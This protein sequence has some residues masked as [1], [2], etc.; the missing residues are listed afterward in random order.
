MECC[1]KINNGQIDKNTMEDIVMK[2]SRKIIA[3]IIL[4]VFVLTNS[5]YANISAAE[6]QYGIGGPHIEENV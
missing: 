4:T 3:A 1:K 6:K 2:L 5:N